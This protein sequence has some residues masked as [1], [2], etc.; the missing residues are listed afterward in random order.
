MESEKY[1]K[2][3]LDDSLSEEEKKIFE[4]SPKFKLFKKLIGSIQAFQAPEYNVEDELVR[5]QS[6]KIG[7]SMR[8][9]WMQPLLQMAA[10][11]FVIIGV[12]FWGLM[13]LI[14]YGFKSVS[15]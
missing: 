2:K 8:T 12:F 4:A 14:Y 15:P 1:I 7:R 9:S 11:L 6:N 10:I 3:W 5:L 13:A